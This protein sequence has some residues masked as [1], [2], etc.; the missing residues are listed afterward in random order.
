[1]ASDDYTERLK[2][3]PLFDAMEPQA[4]RSLLFAGETRLLRAGETLF[5]RGDSSDCGFV[6]TS[7]SIA[8]ESDAGGPADKI[9]RSPALLGETA[10]VAA[11]ERAIT[12]IAGE[13]ATLLKISR[14]LF[15][16]ILDQHPLTA[17][18]V[19]EYFRN[20]LEELGKELKFD[21]SP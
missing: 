8:F 10:L 19:R 9:V 21:M 6:L 14:E 11:T 12:A 2:R 4:L 5:R 7:G 13:P 15:H 18:Q 20:R 3:I 16:Q 17:T 1:M